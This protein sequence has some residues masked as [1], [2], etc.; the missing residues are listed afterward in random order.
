METLRGQDGVV[1]YLDFD[2]VLH[3]EDVWWHPRRGAFIKTPGYRLF[4]H[5]ALLE[6]VLAPFPEID[7][8]LSTSWV[9]FRGYSKTVKRLSPVLRERV[10]GATYHTGMNRDSF[11]ALPRGIQVLND[12]A[13]RK[14]RQWLALDDDAPGWVP[15]YRKH[16]IQTDPA[17][18]LSAHGA[19]EELHEHLARIH[20]PG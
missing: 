13:R 12:V 16:L 8:V 18:G 17:L 10:V 4:E 6:R 3:H 15:E 19:L 11:A 2:G 5:I 1:L 9:R 14:P 20:S 7:I